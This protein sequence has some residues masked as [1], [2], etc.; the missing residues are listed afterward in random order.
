M[1]TAHTH[2]AHVSLS[3]FVRRASRFNTTNAFYSITVDGK[4]GEILW[5][6]VSITINMQN[7]RY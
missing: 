3:L 6:C 7:N 4:K 2:N 1:I 5:Q